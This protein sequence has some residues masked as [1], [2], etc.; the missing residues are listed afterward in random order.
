MEIYGKTAFRLQ[1]LAGAV[2]NKDA[3]MLEKLYIKLYDSRSE[4]GYNN[5]SGSASSCR[6]FWANFRRN[7]FMRAWSLFLKRMDC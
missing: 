3:R 2:D 1:T 4:L 5:L 7:G 6:K